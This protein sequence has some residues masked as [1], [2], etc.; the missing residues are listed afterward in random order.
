MVPMS[1]SEV[2]RLEALELRVDALTDAVNGMADRIPRQGKFVRF[3]T[4]G[5]VVLALLSFSG[6]VTARVLTLWVQMD[7]DHEA[8]STH[9]TK[10]DRLA[11]N[12]ERI[13]VAQEDFCSRATILWA[14][15]GETIQCLRTTL[16][17]LESDRRWRR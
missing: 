8:L 3:I 12:Q 13:L 6:A 9:D 10:F 1:R 2:S 16:H 7:Q 15:R 4:Q 5:W 17:P 14:K 11:V